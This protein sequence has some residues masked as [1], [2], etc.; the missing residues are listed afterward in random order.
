MHQCR[1]GWHLADDPLPAD[2]SPA[3]DPDD[4]EAPD[5]E[6]APDDAATDPVHP[7]S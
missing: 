6:E 7:P 1:E 2:V 4:E 5:V 3:V